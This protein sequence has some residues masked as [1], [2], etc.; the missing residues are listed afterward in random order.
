MAVSS[1]TCKAA[2]C[3]QIGVPV[4][5]SPAPIPAPGFFVGSFF[6][7][8]RGICLTYIQSCGRRRME[9]LR[10]GARQMSPL[11]CGS[12]KCRG[13]ISGPLFYIHIFFRIVLQ[14]PN[15][16]ALFSFYLCLIAVCLS[17][18]TCLFLP[19][20]FFAWCFNFAS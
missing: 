3:L 6:L 14:S 19:H 13:I 9:V 11:E 7:C 16:V 12:H 20:M 4:R 18:S 1:Q 17:F 5:Q 15:F 8:A 2:K 10:K